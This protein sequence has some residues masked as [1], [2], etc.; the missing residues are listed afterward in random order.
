MQRTI[1]FGTVLAGAIALAGGGTSQDPQFTKDNQLIRP[2]NY[3][4]WIYVTTGVG[5]SYT[6]EKTH[7]ANPEFDNI[8][9]APAAYRAFLQTGKWPDK[10][11]FVLEVRSSA[12]HGSINQGGHFQSDL[13]SVEASVKDES[14]FPEKWAY[15]S[16]GGPKPR[17]TAEAFPAEMCHSCHGKHGAVDSTFVQFYPT[18]LE[19]AKAKGTLQTG[20]SEPSP[21]GS[22]K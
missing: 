11:M 18:L 21:H 9:V 3:R 14:R 7:A 6:P 12:S 8:F 20:A 19:V 5:M 15:F 10:T 22:S 1:L 2:A 16:F 13:V 4:E 17:P